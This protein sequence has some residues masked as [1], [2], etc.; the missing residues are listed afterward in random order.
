MARLKYDKPLRE[1]LKDMLTAW[2]LQPG[3]VFTKSR[4]LEWFGERYLLFSQKSAFV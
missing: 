3:Q 4:V 2:E 1:L